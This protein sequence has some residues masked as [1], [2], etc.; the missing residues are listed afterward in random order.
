MSL[1]FLFFILIGCETEKV[2][3]EEPQIE[4]GAQQM[5]TY[6][7]VLEG[8]RVGLTVNH[9]SK[10]GD[11]HLVDTL[12]GRNISVV[13]VFGPEHGFRGQASDGEKI[14][15]DSTENYQIISL[16][17]KKRKPSPEDLSGIDIMVFDIQDVGTRFYTYIS[18]MH[19]VMEA[20]AE[21]DVQVIILDRPNPNGFYVDGPMREEGFE[22]FVGMHPI[23]VVHG[24]TV[25]E[26]AQMINN[27]GW[28][29]NGAKCDLLIIPN[30]NYTHADRWH[31]PD[32]PSPNLPNNVSIGWYPTLCF[33]EGTKMS[34]GRGTHF[35]FQ[36]IGYPD[37]SFGSF[38]FTPVSIEGV[39]KYPK[40]E[41]ELCFG[42]DLRQKPPPGQIDLSFI[43]SFY[44]KFE[45]KESFFITSFNRLAGTDKL[46][47]QIKNGWS[48]SKIRSSWESD[49]AG[50]EVMRKK[51]LLYPD[52]E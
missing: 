26:L 8:K 42:L 2:P 13:S 48:E 1:L 25:G 51:Y 9:T 35:P 31:V 15:D 30:K 20:C 12:I 17:G 22:S 21:N 49:L 11:T 34:I 32:S 10:I 40:F 18:T 19:Y 47:E 37:P 23:P 43:I 52:F 36:V 39:S 14:A 41:N 5:Q 3:Q 16:Y 7:P 50:Y 4:T 33:F 29:K 38:E 27:E 6:L 24:L 46:Q 45:D 44:E 28:L